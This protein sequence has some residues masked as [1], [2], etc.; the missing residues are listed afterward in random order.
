MVMEGSWVPGAER[1]RSI[2]DVLALRPDLAGPLDELMAKLRTGPVDAE[3]LESCEALVRQRIGVPVT[4]P[5]PDTASP[6]LDAR[7]RAVLFL[8]EQF[9]IDPHG[10]DVDLRDAVLD[11]CSLAELATLVQALAMFD[12]LARMEAV[13]TRPDEE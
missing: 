8:A 6:D 4:R 10:I 5:V 1:A 13:L 12:A 11:H 9:V 3:L 2:D 7:T